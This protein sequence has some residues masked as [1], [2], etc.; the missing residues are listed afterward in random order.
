MRIVLFRMVPVFLLIPLSMTTPDIS[1]ISKLVSRLFG[2]L[3]HGTLPDHVIHLH[4]QNFVT[5]VCNLSVRL[6]RHHRC[7]G[8][9][10]NPA[11]NNVLILIIVR[12][13]VMSSGV[14]SVS[15]HR[16]SPDFI[17]RDQ[18]EMIPRLVIISKT[19][20]K[21]KR[22]ICWLSTWITFLDRSGTTTILWTGKPIQSSLY[23]I[24]LVLR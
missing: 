6:R 7:L 8:R 1:V 22:V 21:A 9:H 19:K 24:L 20:R 12:I 18:N 3:Q 16:I 23:S 10:R 17:T 5:I 14:I 15:I 4:K 11:V 2:G 13:T